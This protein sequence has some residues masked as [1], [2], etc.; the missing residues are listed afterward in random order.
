MGRDGLAAGQREDVTGSDGVKSGADASKRPQ[1]ADGI[2]K[3]R[4]KQKEKRSLCASGVPERQLLIL[5]CTK[6]EDEE[7]ELNV[8]EGHSRYFSPQSGRRYVLIL[9][10]PRP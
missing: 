10:D 3:N 4:N 5:P 8:V 7:A 6:P 9:P 2:N 1:W